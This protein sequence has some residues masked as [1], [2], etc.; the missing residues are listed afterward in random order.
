MNHNANPIISKEF[1]IFFLALYNSGYGKMV[2]IHTGELSLSEVND[3]EG[4]VRKEHL[5]ETKQV[6]KGRHDVEAWLALLEQKL[7]LLTVA[8]QQS[9]EEMFG[10]GWESLTREERKTLVSD[11]RDGRRNRVCGCVS[12]P[13]HTQ[14]HFDCIIS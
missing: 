13:G 3:T 11:I 10:S 5:Q 14:L 12:E 9:Q 8:Y 2:T 7:P 1:R 4:R 6:Q